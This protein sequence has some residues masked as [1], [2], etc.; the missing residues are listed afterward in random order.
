MIHNIDTEVLDQYLV[1]V[2]YHVHDF[3]RVVGRWLVS[4]RCWRRLA[5]SAERFLSILF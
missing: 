5:E 4:D 2:V 1:T 3:S